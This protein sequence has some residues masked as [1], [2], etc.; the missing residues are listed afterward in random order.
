MSLL[1][2]I[3]KV[4]K[5]VDLNGDN[6]ITEAQLFDQVETEEMRNAIS[7]AL[8]TVERDEDGGIDLGKLLKLLE[9]PPSE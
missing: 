8:A 5:N 2:F 4:I 3:S 9:E 6:K 7:K 1:E